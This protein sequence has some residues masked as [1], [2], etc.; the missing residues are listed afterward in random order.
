MDF[1]DPMRCHSTTYVA[2]RGGRIINTTSLSGM[3]GNFGQAN[4]S[5][6]KAGI[7]GLTRTASMEFA[8]IGV[9]V[10][11]IAPVA[12]TR[13]TEDLPQLS[14][15]APGAGAELTPDRVT[16]M[17]LFLASEQAKEITGRIFGCQGGRFFEYWVE[18]NE[19]WTKRDGVPT[20]A[21]IAL[22]FR[23]IARG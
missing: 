10:N 21:E 22:N 3:I 5:A 18:T 15:L 1:P 20:V 2:G 23:A 11:A 14:Q 8:K 16:P 13:M 12:L 7:Y 4:Y 17:V 19:G 6:A 9:T